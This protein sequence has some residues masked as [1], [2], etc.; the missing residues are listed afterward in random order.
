[1]SALSRF[2]SPVVL[3]NMLILLGFLLGSATT[4]PAQHVYRILNDERE[5]LQCRIDQMQQAQ[6]E[7]LLSTFII[8]NDVIGR[9]MLQLL[10][11][12]AKRGVK[13]KMII[14]DLGNRLPA[15]LLS[16]MAEQGVEN[17]VFNIKRLAHFRTMVDRMHGK[18]LIVDNQQFI[19]GGRNLKEEYYNLDSVSNF[20]DREVFVR[21]TN[22]VRAAHRHFYD[23]WDFPKVIGKKR[24]V[25]TDEK[26]AYWHQSLEEAPEELQKRLRISLHSNRNWRAGVVSAQGQ[27][28][29]IHD[30]FFEKKGKKT[31][32]RARKDHQCTEAMLS[33]ICNA[34]HSIDIENAYFIPTH[35]WW[36][37]LKQAHK[38]GVRIRLLTNSGYTSD[39]PMVQAVYQMKRGRYR[40]HGIE[41]WEFEGRKMVH[42]KAFV[43]DSTISL[44]GSYNIERKSQDFNTEVA[45]WVN[46]PRIAAEHTSLM[47]NNLSRSVKVGSQVK[48]PA[49]LVP[50]FTKL[51]LKRHRKANFY[52]Y[53][54]APL[55]SL[56][57]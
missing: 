27:V 53:T 30:N 19:I 36:K 33:L 39:V 29:F 12:A 34:Q 41:V 26:R 23:M 55:A 32:R 47:Q 14:D 56:F 18:M 40:R 7:I 11:E 20:L 49:A 35:S 50:A 15:D 5:A 10:I 51:Q 2:F 48:T 44:I 37:A 24:G 31:V 22:A 6:S 45:A 1:M 16:Y 28:Q 25:L 17:R 9:T 13:V 42:T 54:L 21:D 38:R 8:K 46:D 3:K 4:L 43:I 57:L 52:Q